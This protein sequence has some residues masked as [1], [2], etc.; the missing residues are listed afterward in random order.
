MSMRMTKLKSIAGCRGF[1]VSRWRSASGT[2]VARFA[3]CLK[4]V[5]RANGQP[6]RNWQAVVVGGGVI[7]GLTQVGKWPDERIA[8]VL[9]GESAIAGR[10]PRT[11]ELAAHMA[12]D[13]S[14]RAGTRYDALRMIALAGWESR[15]AHLLRYLADGVPNGLQMGAVS[16]LADMQ[17]DAVVK[18]LI[19]ALPRLSTRNQKLA[20]EGLVRTEARSLALIAALESGKVSQDLVDLNL[21]LDHPAA[22]VRAAAR[23]LKN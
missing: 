13:E 8:D 3:T 16:G 23:G 1:G 5:C 22:T 2:T 12:D 10:W 17:S 15:G 4:S 7:N 6:L 20:I 21:L 14:V 11:L 9:S 18:P 19:D